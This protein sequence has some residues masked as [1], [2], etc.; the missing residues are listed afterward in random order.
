M[1]SMQ[2]CRSAQWDNAGCPCHYRTQVNDKHV[3]TFSNKTLYNLIVN[4]GQ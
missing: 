1:F 2:H 4:L 3:I